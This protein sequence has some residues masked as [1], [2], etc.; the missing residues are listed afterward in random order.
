MDLPPIHNNNKKYMLNQSLPS[1]IDVPTISFPT[2]YNHENQNPNHFQ[3][4]NYNTSSH[5]SN[6]QQ[7]FSSQL[8]MPNPSSN[9]NGYYSNYPSS[10]QPRMS[11][12]ASTTTASEH[13]MKMAQ[14]F[15]LP[16]PTIPPSQPST[17]LM[18]TQSY[19][20]TFLVPANHSSTSK[21]LSA[22]NL[23]TSS[24]D[25]SSTP[26]VQPPFTVSTSINSSSGLFSTISPLNSPS[27]PTNEHKDD[28][29][30]SHTK[31]N[32][33]LFRTIDLTASGNENGGNYLPYNEIKYP[34]LDKGLLTASGI[35]TTGSEHIPAPS[36]SADIDSMW[37]LGFLDHE[38][39]TKDQGRKRDFHD[40]EQMFYVKGPETKAEEKKA[41]KQQ[42]KDL[43]TEES[44]TTNHHSSSNSNQGGGGEKQSK[45]SFLSGAE[46]A[47]LRELQL[48]FLAEKAKTGP[49][50]A[51]KLATSAYAK[52][53]AK[54]RKVLTLR[55]ESGQRKLKRLFK[56]L[57]KTMQSTAMD[58]LLYLERLESQAA[59]VLQR[60]YRRYS[61][62]CFWRK[63][64]KESKAATTIQRCYRGYRARI[65]A[66]EHKKRQD[67]LALKLQAS[68]RGKLARDKLAREK[69]FENRAGEDI[70]RIWRGHF[71]R[72]KAQR[73]VRKKA[74]IKIQRLWRGLRG[75][76][77]AD[78]L[79]LD[80]CAGLIQRHVLRWL[81]QKKYR[82]ALKLET[83]AA[84]QIQSAFRGWRVRQRRNTQL[85]EKES[86][87]RKVWMSILKS[88]EVWLNK[89]IIALGK[90]ATKQDIDGQIKTLQTEWEAIQAT[91]AEKEFDL[92][93]LQTERVKLSPRAV[94]QG[95]SAQLDKDVL[96]HR[97]WVT[98]HK[99]NAL[100][101]IAQPLREFRNK[102]EKLTLRLEDMIAN[103]HRFTE[104]W[105]ADR[106]DLWKRENELTWGKRRYELAKRS[107]DERRKWA[108]K[109]FTD[110]GK[111]DMAR[112]PGQP[113][114][115]ED[116]PLAESRAITIAHGDVMALTKPDNLA[117]DP[118]VLEAQQ[119]DAKL[120]LQY[121][122]AQQILDARNRFGGQVEWA[123]PNEVL[124]DTYNGIVEGQQVLLLPD[125][126]VAVSS[127]DANNIGAGNG[128]GI[129]NGTVPNFGNNRAAMGS[130]STY[131]DDPL[132]RVGPPPGFNGN[133]SLLPGFVPLGGPT[134]N[135]HPN[136]GF[137][138]HMG[139][140]TQG[141]TKPN[142]N[143]GQGPSSSTASVISSVEPSLAELSQHQHD[144]QELHTHVDNNTA[145]Q[146]VGFAD[147]DKVIQIRPDLRAG[148]N[149]YQVGTGKAL[150]SIF[151]I[152]PEGA[153]GKVMTVGHYFGDEFGYGIS[154]NQEEQIHSVLVQRAKENLKPLHQRVW[155][156]SISRY[157]GV[158][159]TST[160]PLSKNRARTEAAGHVEDARQNY[161]SNVASQFAE[162][163]RGGINIDNDLDSLDGSLSTRR[164]RHIDQNMIDEQAR[165]RGVPT[166]VG[167]IKDKAANAATTD[168]PDEM[169]QAT[170]ILEQKARDIAAI[171]RLAPGLAGARA[172][173]AASVIAASRAK[174]TIG[175]TNVR[176]TALDRAE[177]RTKE[178]ETMDRQSIRIQ[179]LTQKIA[180]VSGQAELLQYGALTKPLMDGMATLQQHLMA[181]DGTANTIVQAADMR[182]RKEIERTTKLE[183]VRETIRQQR[184]TEPSSVPS[185]SASNSR[186][187]SQYNS[188]NDQTLS[189]TMLLNRTINIEETDTKNNKLTETYYPPPSSKGSSKMMNNTQLSLM[190]T[191]PSSTHMDR[192]VS[193][194]TKRDQELLLAHQK[195]LELE[196]SV[197]RLKKTQSRVRAQ[198]AV[199]DANAALQRAG[200]IWSDAQ[201][202]SSSSNTNTNVPHAR[203]TW[204]LQD[205]IE[206][207]R[208]R[209]TEQA[210]KPLP[211][212]TGVTNI[213]TTTTTS[214]TKKS[215]GTGKPPIA[216]RK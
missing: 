132:I 108:V 12:T 41:L 17:T 122:M 72:V 20:D 117:I 133:Q 107:A 212:P 32:L 142:N 184:L 91:I 25:P 152:V 83:E 44:K 119:R 64:L 127:N 2:Y 190:D 165:M 102:K 134:S 211:F 23:H 70:Q 144:L 75:R 128:I 138:P 141:N 54:I 33:P 118:A 173:A 179:Q 101:K 170:A 174:G 69:E 68:A 114:V 183:N 15:G 198:M 149:T 204:N 187:N 178:Q 4:N 14:R 100:F 87:A 176:K 67:M 6:Q 213:K 84:I 94:E 73:R 131:D 171:A 188:Y 21:S 31:T 206:A 30:N 35:H 92:V 169:R 9:T 214:N 40:Y 148:A 34:A 147:S 43:F 90:F 153:R 104:R 121:T 150:A 189:G 57:P 136:N 81:A 185:T 55:G 97:N 80:K 66:R 197:Q 53:N 24:S 61:R 110:S 145:A 182:A 163:E 74:A 191:L 103:R 210:E 164:S 160:D 215:S 216:K 111:V 177:M 82:I 11:N 154:G 37:L 181:A 86:E 38:N 7:Q 96:E 126:T 109:Y 113:L 48:Q 5:F 49:S 202:S 60:A 129:N 157:A 125:G 194:A 192:A 8:T 42:Q 135:N 45:H 120:R 200:D 79:Y 155:E 116:F 209:M 1:P 10:S 56:P 130:S 89:E 167:M 201:S 139:S 115:L 162:N 3:S 28:I 199:Q 161:A 58:N 76:A 106:T 47:R 208:V 88:E 18:R 63:Y 124:V 19:N 16:M 168:I 146:Y 59:I 27:V 195:A 36:A 77:K 172:G 71:F 39:T 159:P 137:S 158:G 180:A 46:I 50:A 156:T 51:D 65:A 13:A 207:E 78:K 85:F 196:N 62:I 151:G 175:Q 52:E 95:W 98:D 193:A 93:S 26:G 205:E 112:R 22:H 203:S 123:N 143:A 140:P 166:Y 186:K 99:V 29:Y 105:E